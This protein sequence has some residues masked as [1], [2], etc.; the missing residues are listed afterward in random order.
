MAV[1]SPD[2]E[3]TVVG[4]A[5]RL[6]AIESGLTFVRNFIFRGPAAA[7]RHQYLHHIPSLLV[8]TPILK[9]TLI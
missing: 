2:A 1:S 7:R 5:H 6:S 3:Q 9:A 4:G 8:I